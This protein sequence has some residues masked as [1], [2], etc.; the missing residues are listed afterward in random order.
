MTTK[1]L[2]CFVCKSNLGSPSHLSGSFLQVSSGGE[3]IMI[4]PSCGRV[5]PVKIIEGQVLN[6]ENREAGWK[7]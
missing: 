7:K 5:N 4:C 2:A 6:D 1:R 3:I